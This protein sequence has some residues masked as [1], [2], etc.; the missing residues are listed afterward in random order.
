MTIVC[1]DP[2]YYTHGCARARATKNY[3]PQ[4][5]IIDARRGDSIDI[6]SRGLV[7]QFMESVES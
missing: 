1:F 4:S 7:Y 6:A 5:K 3:N 2:R